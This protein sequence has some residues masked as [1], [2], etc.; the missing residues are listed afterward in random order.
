MK[1]KFLILICLVLF[2]VSVACVSAAEDVNQTVDDALS[3]SVDNELGVKDNGTFTALQEKINNAG[4]GSTINLE[5]DYK[6]DEGFRKEGISINKELT[7]DGN[8]YTID[9]NNE[10][11]IFEILSNDV[12]VRNI[13]FIN[14]GFS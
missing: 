4:A 14:D 11:R 1:R 3:V 8:G 9:G 2:I 5:N 12:T 7:I 6:Y 10:A 13:K